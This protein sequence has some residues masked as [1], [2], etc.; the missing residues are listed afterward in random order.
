MSGW[1][2]ETAGEPKEPDTAVVAAADGQFHLAVA[3][4]VGGAGGYQVAGEGIE[5]SVCA[6]EGAA[7]ERGYGCG[8][9]AVIQRHGWAGVVS[10]EDGK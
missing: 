10:V 8:T 9:G 4:G 7:V 3:G 1:A 2:T 6:V 5:P